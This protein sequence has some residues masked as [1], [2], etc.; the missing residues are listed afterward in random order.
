MPVQVRSSGRRLDAGPVLEVSGLTKSFGARIILS[1]VTFSLQHGDLLVI[2]GP[3][4]AG[5]TTLLRLLAGISRPTGGTIMIMGRRLQPSSPHLRS[6]IGYVG[7]EALAYQ[8]L[9]GYENLAFFA[10]AYGIA[11]APAKVAGTLQWW[12][13]AGAGRQLVRTY[14][15]GMRQRLALGRASLHDPVLLLLDEPFAGLDPE[16]RRLL[17][18]FLQRHRDNGGVAIM[19]THDATD[20]QRLQGKAATIAS[21]RLMINC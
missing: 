4:G 18:E 12:G 8:D 10:A 11:N 1:D 15:R 6:H 13:L 2:T 19:T 16:G 17:D 14:S 9:T 5:K 7:H 3:N 21:G 20:V